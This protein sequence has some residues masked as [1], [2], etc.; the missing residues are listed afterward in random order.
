MS[1]CLSSWCRRPRHSGFLMAK[2]GR[3]LLCRV[4]SSQTWFCGVAQR[5]HMSGHSVID[6]WQDHWLP[7]P[8]PSSPNVF[9][10]REATTPNGSIVKTIS[11]LEQI[12]QN[13]K[14]Q[15]YPLTIE[16]SSPFSR[17]W[18]SLLF[19]FYCILRKSKEYQAKSRRLWIERKW[20]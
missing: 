3:L 15:I 7:E 16:N 1:A 14:T 17:S 2:G 18:I 8:V 6:L 11:I 20:K 13:P 4:T 10:F 12:V 5:N 19:D 9:D